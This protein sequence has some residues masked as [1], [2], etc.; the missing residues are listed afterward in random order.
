MAESTSVAL[1]T[2]IAKHT[3]AGLDASQHHR[4][5]DALHR[6]GQIGF[7]LQAIEST[8]DTASPAVNQISN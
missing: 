5:I 4:W 7:A 3:L 6:D 1:G 8:V 2:G